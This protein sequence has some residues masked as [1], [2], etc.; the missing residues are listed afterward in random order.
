[1]L[2]EL[3]QRFPAYRE[4]LSRGARHFAE[5]SE[6]LDELAQMDARDAL[7]DGALEV[8]RLQALSVPRAKNLLRY[9]LHSLGAPMPQA[10]QLD[11]MLQQL[12]EA[13][14]GAAV[15]ITFGNW[16]LRRYRGKAYALPA[17]SEPGVEF[18]ASWYGESTLKLPELGGTLYFESAV[19]RGL[20][21]E[22]LQQAAV[23]VRLR[24]GA[25][26]IRPD[27]KRP[28]RTLK[29]LLQEHGM[30]PW[31]RDSLPLLYCGDALV[32]VPGIGVECAY[33][34]EAGEVGLVLR[35]DVLAARKAGE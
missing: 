32:A 14:Q 16:Q 20:S 4:A 15:Q 11:E 3:E 19:G 6:L 31:R 29:N 12:C 26:K 18:C 21:L 23:S 28:A 22:K 13:R 2:P 8:G 7:H 34:A 35:W 9:F 33:Q 25:E 5:A 24:R 30:P 10:V 17:L 27:C 1:V